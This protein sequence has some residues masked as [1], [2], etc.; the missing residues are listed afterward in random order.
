[1]KVTVNF[2]NVRVIVPCGDGDLL[3]RDLMQL[4]IT[5]YKKATAKV[6]FQTFLNILKPSSLGFWLNEPYFTMVLPSLPS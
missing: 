2:D 5:R 1:M 6:N 3:V 4:A